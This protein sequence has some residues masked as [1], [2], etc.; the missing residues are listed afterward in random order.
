MWIENKHKTSFNSNSYN[1]LKDKLSYISFVRYSVS[2]VDSKF[3][4]HLCFHWFWGLFFQKQS[5]KWHGLL[6]DVFSWKFKYSFLEYKLDTC[7][8]ICWCIFSNNLYAQLY[9]KMIDIEI[10]SNPCIG[11]FRLQDNSAYNTALS[12]CDRSGH[13]RSKY[14]LIQ[15]EHDR[16]LSVALHVHGH[17][18]C[19]R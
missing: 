19:G 12:A 16:W 2:R 1:N 3:N 18:R 8:Q 17:D 14:S 4:W 5:T 15:R 11:L 7:L 9:L 10:I 6:R 13:G